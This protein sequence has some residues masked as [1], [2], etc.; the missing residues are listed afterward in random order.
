M[1]IRQTPADALQIQSRIHQ[2]DQLGEFDGPTPKPAQVVQMLDAKAPKQVTLRLLTR[3]H[4]RSFVAGVDKK[5]TPV[6]VISE[7]AQLAVE[8]VASFTG[9]TWERLAAPRGQLLIAHES[10]AAKVCSTAVAGVF[11]QQLPK[12]KAVLQSHG[13][14]GQGARQMKFTSVMPR[15]KLENIKSLWP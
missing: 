10:L 5:D 6:T 7:W 4:Y 9:T 13:R 1:G 11:L 12:N 2:L 14:P 15:N 3:E 8:P